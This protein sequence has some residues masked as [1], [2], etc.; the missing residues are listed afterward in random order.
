[1]LT[2]TADL[3]VKP[4]HQHDTEHKGS[5]FLHLAFLGHRAQHRHSGTQTTDKIVGHRFIN[6]DQIFFL[7]VVTGTQD[8][9][10]QIA[11]VGKE[12]QPLRVFIQPPDREDT[13]TVVDEI[14][15]IVFL[16][17]FGGADD[18]HRL[19]QRNKN[20]V[21]FVTGFNKLPINLD[22]VASEYPIAERYALTVDKNI[23]LFDVTIGIAT[24]A[25]AALANIFVE[26]Y[27]WFSQ[28]GSSV[29]AK[30]TLSSRQYFHDGLT[31]KGRCQAGAACS[32]P[33]VDYVRPLPI[34]Q[35]DLALLFGSL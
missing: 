13:G 25:D 23:A 7:V 6:R 14:D 11:V 31:G 32:A 30:Y 27:R 15:N 9:V 17:V 16:T 18:T 21:V 26:A 8:L 28:H 22:H 4:L 2:H 29:N 12:D 5:F 33:T 1:M 24:R 34:Q 35:T 10:H 19:V 20:Q 3:A